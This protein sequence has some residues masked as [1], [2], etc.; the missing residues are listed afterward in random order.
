MRVP[1]TQLPN[2]P[3]QVTLRFKYGTPEQ[4]LS[5]FVY[6]VSTL[7]PFLAYK[8][9]L[10]NS[11]TLP[12]HHPEQLQKVGIPVILRYISIDPI[13]RNHTRISSSSTLQPLKLQ[14]QVSHSG[15]HILF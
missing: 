6:C 13:Q 15:T 4:C 12:N 7:N 9:G 5:F 2:F 8:S 1:G 14:L 11:L 3:N 10:R